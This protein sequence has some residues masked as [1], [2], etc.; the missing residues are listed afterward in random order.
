M[1]PKITAFTEKKII[2]CKQS[3]NY[4]TY[5][6]VPLWQHFMPRKKEIVNAISTDLF[7]IQQF[8]E[9]FWENFNPNTEFEKWVA[10]E[11]TDFEN[12]PDGM[13]SLVIPNGWYAVFDYKGDGSDAAAFFEYIFKDWIPNSS[14]VVD[15]RPHFE[16][17]GEKYKKGD[18]DSEEEIWIPIRL[19]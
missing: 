17:L 10:V 11:V 12:I 3:M 9:G 2:G 1:K 15:D 4:A 18:P 16:I 13:N 7:S 6:P 19:K 5:N 14:Y 8:L